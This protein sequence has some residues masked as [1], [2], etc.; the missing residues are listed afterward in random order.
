MFLKG[1]ITMKFNRISRVFLSFLLASGIQLSLTTCTKSG[2]VIDSDI[3][4]SQS[5]EYDKEEIEEVYH[6]GK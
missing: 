6:F 5:I 2:E 4:K 1:V 3:E